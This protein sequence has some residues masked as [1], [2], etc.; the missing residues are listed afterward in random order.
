MAMVLY[1]LLNRMLLL[2]SLVRD[3]GEACSAS[4]GAFF[5]D[6]CPTLTLLPHTQTPMPTLI[7]PQSTVIQMIIYSKYSGRLTCTVFN[8]VFVDQYRGP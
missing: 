6:V 4:A 2:Y 8:L 5:N 1:A 3:V 7:R